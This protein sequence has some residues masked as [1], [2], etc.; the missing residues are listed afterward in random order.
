LLKD[1]EILPILPAEDIYG[2]RKNYE[3]TPGERA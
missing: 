3:E 2:A 1:S